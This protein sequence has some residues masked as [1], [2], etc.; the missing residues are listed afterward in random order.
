MGKDPWDSPA[1]HRTLGNLRENAADFLSNEINFKNA[2]NYFNVVNM[3][4]LDGPN[5]TNIIDIII[6]P[7]LHVLIGVTSKL[8]QE[9]KKVDTYC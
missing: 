3:P 6:P 9:L 7:E 2:K 4:L 8:T 5:D 1:L